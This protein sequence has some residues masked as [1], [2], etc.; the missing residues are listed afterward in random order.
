EDIDSLV[1]WS[2]RNS[3]FLNSKK[4]VT[5]RFSLSCSSRPL[6]SIDGSEVSVPESHKDLGVIVRGDLSWSDHYSHTCSKAYKTLYVI[7]RS[8][9][10][11]SIEV[12]GRLY[13]SQVR[14]KMLYC[15]QVW[16]PNLK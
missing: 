13:I 16:H 5:I 8:F 6:Y 12:K 11:D 2:K 15:S 7:K 4:C 1:E 14:S 10:T 3:L 9:S